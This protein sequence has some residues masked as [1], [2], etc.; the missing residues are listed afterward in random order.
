MY[1]ERGNDNQT[2]MQLQY[3]GLS[4]P[5]VFVTTLK[6]GGTGLHQMAAIHAALVRKYQVL[7]K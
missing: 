4:N 5:A 6:I 7:N 2:E 1:A 3:Q